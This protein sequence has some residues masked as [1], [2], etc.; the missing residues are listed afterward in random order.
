M[1]VKKK[2]TVP[3]VIPVVTPFAP[4]EALVPLTPIT[5][6]E[7]GSQSWA[8]P[9]RHLP[10]PPMPPFVCLSFLFRR[11]FFF[12]SPSQIPLHVCEL[13]LHVCELPLR[14]VW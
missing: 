2:T 6:L 10:P 11:G 8:H 14:D 9:F 3:L 13:P 12:K 7:L 1:H 4:I 5:S